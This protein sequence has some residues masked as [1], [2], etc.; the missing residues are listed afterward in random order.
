MQLA[1]IY[2]LFCAALCAG[3]DQTL[4]R[5]GDQSLE[6]TQT[7]TPKP[8]PPTGASHQPEIVV[9]GPSRTG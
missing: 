3:H 1:F 6:K 5:R 8:P 9:R 7:N 2:P 4:V